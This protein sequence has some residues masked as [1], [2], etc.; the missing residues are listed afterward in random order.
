MGVR[1]RY[2]TIGLGLLFLMYAA[3]CDGGA[4]PSAGN[5]KGPNVSAQPI[6]IEQDT[7]G[8]GLLGWFGG[9]DRQRFSLDPWQPGWCP[10]D[11][12]GLGPGTTTVTV[13]GPQVQGVATHT[14]NAQEPAGGGETDLNVVVAADGTVQFDG[15]VPSFP[16]SCTSYPEQTA[17]PQ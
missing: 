7:P 6:V 11:R 13:S 2:S 1:S 12:L 5:L 9:T 8:T 3:G 16:T 14:W 4:A 15:P 17:P 10:T